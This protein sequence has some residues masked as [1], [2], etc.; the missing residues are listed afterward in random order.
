MLFIFV[1]VVSA[2]VCATNQQDTGFIPLVT[3]NFHEKLNS[4]LEQQILAFHNQELAFRA[5]S[6]YFG[7]ADV[8]LPGFKKLLKSLQDRA[9]ENALSTTTYI[10]DR[11]GR[12]RFPVV[13]LK[14]ACNEITKALTSYEVIH[15]SYSSSSRTEPYICNFLLTPTKNSKYDSG[16]KS[17]TEDNDDSDMKS[18]E[19]REDWMTGLYAL[20]DAL[21]LEKSIN[22]GLINLAKESVNF[23]DPKTRDQ[24]EQ[25]L[26][27]QVEVIQKLAELITKLRKYKQD[28]DYILGEYLINNQLDS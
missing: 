18:V 23:E 14:D 26:D 13:Q 22:N 15:P 24:V 10:N 4:K 6:S 19:T 12:V 1:I 11:G 9:L 17:K 7:R 20:E 16:K 8:N 21:A 25:Y 27:K 28:G 2:F 5:Y 3:Q